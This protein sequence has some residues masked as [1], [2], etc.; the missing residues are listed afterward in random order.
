M[1]PLLFSIDPI[2]AALE[3]AVAHSPLPTGTVRVCHATEDEWNAFADSED[4]IAR[5]N[6]LEWF[7]DME[8]IHIIEFADAPHENLH[9]RA[10]RIS[11]GPRQATPDSV[12]PPNVSIFADFRKIKVEIGVSQQWGMAPGE[13]DQKAIAIWAAMPGVEYE[14]CVSFDPNFANAEY[15]FWTNVES[16]VFRHGWRSL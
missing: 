15:K 1:T 5:R 10:K 4:P 12:L 8:E 14:L 16:L 6:Y 7:P 3:A 13:L 9:C 2:N 11:Y